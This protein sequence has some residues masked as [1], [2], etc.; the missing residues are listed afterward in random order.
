MKHSLLKK[1]LMIMLAGMGGGKWGS[2]PAEGAE[3]FW[4]GMGKTYS[5]AKRQELR[6]PAPYES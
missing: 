5:A 1:S 4:L 2:S 6:V 3:S